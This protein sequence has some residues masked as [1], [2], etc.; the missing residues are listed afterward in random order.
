M[1][2][3]HEFHAM[4]SITRVHLAYCK[5]ALAN[6]PPVLCG[7]SCST[8]CLSPIEMLA[9]LGSIAYLSQRVW[10]VL[11]SSSPAVPAGPWQELPLRAL[12]RTA[13]G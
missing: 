11:A 13:L 9:S 7:V 6:A 3:E 5:S 4:S 1:G 10:A 12:G 8:L 2:V